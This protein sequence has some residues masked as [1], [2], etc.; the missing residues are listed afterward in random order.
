MLD[1]KENLSRVDEDLPRRIYSPD[2]QSLLQAL[3]SNLATLDL[4][5]EQERE[6]LRQVVPDVV[7]QKRALRRL[8]ERHFERC[9]PFIRHVAAIDAQ[10]Q[11]DTG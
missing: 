3:L 9:E 11:T 1:T 2:L 7:A 6:R 4:G 8:K 10:M 5:Y